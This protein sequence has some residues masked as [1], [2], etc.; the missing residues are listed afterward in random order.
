MKKFLSLFLASLIFA[1]TLSGCNQPDTESEE[2]SSSSEIVSS[3]E[4]D[5]INVEN[6][7][8]TLSFPYG[9][10][11]GIFTGTFQNGVPHGE[12]TFTT[13]NPEGTNWTYSGEF[14]NG[15]FH[16]NGVI[17]WE[18]GARREGTYKNAAL[19]EGK[20]YNDDETLLFEGILED[21]EEYTQNFMDYLSAIQNF[22]YGIFDQTETLF[23]N[24]PNYRDSSEYLE[25]ISS[26]LPYQGEWES[27]INHI[28][29]SGWQIHHIHYSFSYRDE[30]TNIYT[31]DLTLNNDGTLTKS[32]QHGQERGIISINENGEL[33][34]SDKLNNEHNI[35]KISDSTNVPVMKEEPK[36]GMTE[37][38]VILST[39]GYPKK[40]NTTTTVNGTRE[41]LVYDRGYIYL[42]NG[43]VTAIQ[44]R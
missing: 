37:M 35:V 20:I 24:N 23:Q 11:I 14:E 33:I 42:E 44:E 40:R 34:E 41:Q 3:H 5:T 8:I 21:G 2:I 27:K 32:N 43:I 9:E 7:E 16:G 26:M 15:N 19:S 31:F 18:T 30:I 36:I 22:N 6:Q 39:W 13:K 17:E 1:V 28:F 12:G 4:T 10:R 25:K 29:I 38:D